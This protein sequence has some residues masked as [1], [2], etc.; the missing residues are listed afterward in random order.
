MEYIDNTLVDGNSGVYMIGCRHSDLVYIGSSKNLKSRFNRHKHHLLKG[1]HFRKLLQ[2]LSLK[3]GI[4]SFYFEILE[5][6][7]NSDL[8]E[9]EQYHF[10]RLK[11]I[12]VNSRV[13]VES[14]R[15]MKYPKEILEKRKEIMAKLMSEGFVPFANVDRSKRTG[16]N[17]P[18]YGKN[19]SD[20][21]KEKISKANKGRTVS[22]E[23]K[24]KLSERMLSFKHTNRTKDILREK[25][26]GNKNGEGHVCPKELKEANRIRQSKPV[27]Q[28]DMDG[29]FI[30]LWESAKQA[31]QSL[32]INYSSIGLVVSG[33]RNHAGGYV[34]KR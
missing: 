18:M 29:N 23:F 15:G 7:D 13:Y 24:R 16:E 9:I 1:D 17:H 31:S 6:C 11:S 20:K 26:K 2:E 32:G 5:K 14:N 10:E 4:E 19:H 33:E 34:W 25:L 27:K 8:I 28:F 3:H 12:S 22:E 30:K 21:A